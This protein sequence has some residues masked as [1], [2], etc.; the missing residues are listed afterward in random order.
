M[1]RPMRQP[2]RAS[3]ASTG[4]RTAA[5]PG[6]RQGGRGRA[7]PSPR[8]GGSPQKP[9]P[10]RAAARGRAQ[11]GRR[12]ARAAA[13]STRPRS[14]RSRPAAR[15]I[16]LDLPLPF[17]PATCSASPG[18]SARSRSS[19]SSRPPRR[20]ATPSN[21]SKAR[22][23]ALSSSACMSS[24]EKPKWCPTS[25]MTMWLT[26]CS[27]LTPVDCHSSRIGRRKERDPLG[28]NARLADAAGG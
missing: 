7:P 21:R 22:H 24:S 10:G 4:P 6:R 5:A 1:A 26:S 9:A 2:V 11:A 20:S 27:R 8:S 3:H 23:S 16:R 13:R 18:P 28:Q 25:W 19:N 15:R 17:G 14:G 12:R